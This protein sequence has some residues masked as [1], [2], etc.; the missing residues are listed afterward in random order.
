MKKEKRYTAIGSFTRILSKQAKNSPK[1]FILFILLDI[2][3]GLSFGAITLVTQIFFD[4][5][6]LYSKGEIALVAI[7]GAL[8]AMGVMH[9][10]SLAFNALSDKIFRYLVDRSDEVLFEQAYRKAAKLPA[11]QFEDTTF[12]DDLGKVK[13]ATSLAGYSS[14][15]ILS[16]F[17]CYLPYFL[18]MG[19]YLFSLNPI[20]AL[21]IPLVFIPAAFSQILR[22]KLFGKAEDKI[23]PIRREYEYYE[24]CMA[25]REY[26]KET[27]L[28]G[29]YQYFNEKYESSLQALNSTLLKTHL[30]S[31]GLE[32]V[33]KIIGLAGYFTILYLLFL[34]LMDG[35]V[36][37]GAF[38][39]V[40]AS[41]GQLF[42]M[43]DEIVSYR[44]GEVSKNF[45]SV[46][47]LMKFLDLE[48][49]RGEKLLLPDGDIELKGVSF[50]Y[51]GQENL[52][53][54]GVDVTL[55][56]GET[57]AIVGENGSG[58]STLVKLICGLYSPCEG[59]VLHGGIALSTVDP[60]MLYRG[61]SA[62]FQNFQ[63]YQ[64]TLA[65][66]LTIS[67]PESNSSR[68]ELDRVC[69][70]ANVNPEDENFPNGYETMLSREFDGVDLSGGEWQ[71][72]AIAR[73]LF[74]NHHLILLDEPTAA[75]DPIEE[76][77]VYNR[78][79][80][81]SADKT[82]VIVTHRLGSVRLADRI[83]VMKDGKLIGDG[84]HEELLSGNEEY[85]RMFHSQEKWYR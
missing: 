20:L 3:A 40:F 50:R 54:A 1:F 72:I 78:F 66:N 70:L 32:L 5:A 38:A 23:A 4:R 47:N 35:R 77:A 69:S 57:V 17:T 67:D 65:E 44:F 10:I 41:I 82:A 39:A 51:A 83:L 45:G 62:V 21:G 59:Q 80:Q 31:L 9:L 27:R 75:I 55:K 61:T 19:S 36:S 68:E 85:A 43:M 52:A 71:R 12:L 46:R 33:L 13:N 73:G 24:N 79:A 56:K 58:K 18:F 6:E 84:T 48:D 42:N 8:A 60:S 49:R 74:R 22:T 11:E 7:L 15:L 34:S 53:V 81:V 25:G 2:T 63:R 16:V 14:L 26:Y 64:M 30:K 76:T 37:V 28:L 29:N